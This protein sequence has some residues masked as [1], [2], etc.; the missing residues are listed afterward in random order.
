MAVHNEQQ[1]EM[2]GGFSK[3]IDAGAKQ[4]IFD[5]LQRYQYQYPI[6]STV[7]ELVSNG[8]DSVR[9]KK[10]AISILTGVTAV[11]DHYEQREGEVYKDSAF[12]PA[13]Y[14]LY[15]LDGKDEVEIIYC[16]GSNMEKDTVIIR[17]YG[18]G[19]GESRLA[20]Y[21]NLGYSTK[22]LSKYPLGK[23][24]LGA[25]S[26]LSTGAPFYTLISHHNGW[27]YVFNVY[28]HKVESVVPRWNLIDSSENTPFLL[29]G[30][31]D[32]NGL[33]YTMYK[34]KWTGTN[35]VEIHLQAKQHHRQ[36][37]VEAV[38]QQL[39]Y[40]P[41]V[42]MI[43]RA[44]GHD[45]F[46]PTKAQILY[47]DDMIV[48]SKNSPYTVPHLVLNGVNYGI[49]DFKELEL[50][51]K[52]GNIGIKVQPELV[53]VNPSREA[54]IWDDITRATVVDRFNMVVEIASETVSKELKETDFFRWLIACLSAVSSQR[55]WSNSDTVLGR[56]AQIIDMSK[57]ELKYPGDPELHYNY[58][59]LMGINTRRVTLE[60]EREGSKML[61][62]VRYTGASMSDFEAGLPILIQKTATSNRKNKYILQKV[63]PQG[64]I[65]INLEC[66]PEDGRLVTAEDIEFGDHVVALKEFLNDR[67]RKDAKYDIK[68]A[69]QRI[70]NIHNYI[71]AA[72]DLTWYESIV[73]PE[74]F[75]ATDDAVD[76]VEDVVPTKEA[77]Q[78]AAERRKIIGTTTMATPY[79][80]GG[81]YEFKQAE[82]PVNFISSWKNPE[83]YWSNQNDSD[84]LLLA[85]NIAE[86]SGLDHSTASHEEEELR[87][88]FPN[89]KFGNWRDV[90]SS[91]SHFHNDSPVRLMRIAQNNVKL[92]KDFNHINRFFKVIRDKTITMSNL[93]I[94]W[95]TARLINEHMPKLRFMENMENFSP[96]KYDTYMKLK[97]YVERFHSDAYNQSYS[98][99]KKS[100]INDLLAHLDKVT[101]F[102][103]FVQQ[104]PEDKEAISDLARE[105]FNPESGIEITDGCAIELDIY[106]KMEELVDWSSPVSCMLNM[107]GKMRK[108]DPDAFEHEQKMEIINYFGYKQ[109]EL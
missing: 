29:E 21:F 73:V 37:Y 76:I 51:D 6:K 92:Y 102:Q 15:K 89:I 8:L 74:D 52:K 41:N 28:A 80:S 106:R 99:L 4:M 77:E 68:S 61:N 43:V 36:T 63:Y 82:V 100:H 32:R 108:L 30:V 84:L 53:S 16:H 2:S 86:P 69:K 94:K 96:E 81:G 78:S 91:L 48:M 12:D 54:L 103:V 31:N 34:R 40:F 27:E 101:K 7:R 25:K 88:S 71:L 17:D 3:E 62:T 72:D 107:I 64:F 90:Y 19:L 95:N 83:V 13:Y 45:T 1:I 20:G 57:V 66:V 49:I 56:L 39:M 26:P 105:L 79:R 9:E 98:N 87:K 46:V 47:E 22:R 93:L 11:E 35:G 109:C 42:T 10:V 67:K 55:F 85:A 75:K 24:G 104:N 23:F 65:N 38:Q 58:G 18:V 70:A 97:L 60:K 5:N 44:N 50:E 14:D 59:L 33:P